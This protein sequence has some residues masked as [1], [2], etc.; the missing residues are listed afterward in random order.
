MTP[1]QEKRLREIEERVNA[2]YLGPWI[3]E[4]LGCTPL[5]YPCSYASPNDI[6]QPD[7]VFIGHSYDDVEWLIALAREKDDKLHGKGGE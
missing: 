3:E 7:I 2:A 5:Y 6:P 1:E 4:R